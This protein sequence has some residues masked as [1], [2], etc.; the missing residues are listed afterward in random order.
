M[1]IL[2]TIIFYRLKQRDKARCLRHSVPVKN[3]VENEN[4]SVALFSGARVAEHVG[5]YLKRQA[6]QLFFEYSYPVL[7]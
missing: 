7:D 3:Q 1:I 4:I 2:Y 5:K 6:D